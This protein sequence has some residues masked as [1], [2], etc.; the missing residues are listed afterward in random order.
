MDRWDEFNHGTLIICL[1]YVQDFG[2]GVGS[3][4]FM[5]HDAI[6]YKKGLGVDSSE[7]MIHWFN[8]Q[9]CFLSA[10]KSSK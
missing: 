3:F 6:G 7:N 4:T 10:L 5:L 1:N 2:C 8:S 9:V